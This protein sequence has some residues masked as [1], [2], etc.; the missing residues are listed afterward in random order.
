MTLAG[1]DAKHITAFDV[2]S[3][4]YPQITQHRVTEHAIHRSL[5]MTA[6]VAGSVLASCG[7][8]NYNQAAIDRDEI[9]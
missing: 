9:E 6:T 8:A 5:F 3:R 2:K 1:A 7:L 4:A